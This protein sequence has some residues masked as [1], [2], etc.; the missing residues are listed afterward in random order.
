[1]TICISTSAFGFALFNSDATSHLQVWQTFLKQLDLVEL[2]EVIPVNSN[3]PLALLLGVLASVSTVLVKHGVFLSHS[4]RKLF[5]ELDNLS[6]H[7]RNEVESVDEFVKQ[8]DL[9]RKNEVLPPR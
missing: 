5:S 7:L 8:I 1:M 2:G 4:E 6:E 9:S 3:D